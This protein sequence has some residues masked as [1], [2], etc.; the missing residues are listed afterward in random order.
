DEAPPGIGEL[1]DKPP[2]PTGGDPI[3]NEPTADSA[4]G[5]GYR[6]WALRWFKR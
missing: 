5:R 2:E 3:S 1:V 4:G 6:K